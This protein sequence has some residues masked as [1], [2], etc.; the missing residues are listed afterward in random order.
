MP[1]NPSGNSHF[2]IMRSD[3][4]ED[5]WLEF[6]STAGTFANNIPV[7]TVCTNTDFEKKSLKLLTSTVGGNNP[8]D[9]IERISRFK[10]EL[11]TRNRIVTKEDIKAACY[12]ELGNE[13]KH[14]EISSKPMLSQN[15]NI[16]FQNSL[17][18]ILDFKGDKK[19]EEKEILARHMEKTLIQKSSFIYK[20][21]VEAATH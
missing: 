16:G 19:Q 21:Q 4:V 11:L 7:G 5:V 10:N 1:G 3:I 17:H 13:L 8:P 9:Q 15:R 20:Y 2:V 6:W 14:V 18:V 12:A